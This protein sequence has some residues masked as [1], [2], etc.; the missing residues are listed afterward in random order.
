MDHRAFL[1]VMSLLPQQ[2]PFFMARIMRCFFT[3]FHEI[4]FFRTQFLCSRL[5]ICL[6]RRFYNEEQGSFKSYADGGGGA[7][8]N[9]NEDLLTCKG[10]RTIGEGHCPPSY[11]HLIFGSTAPHLLVG[12][13]LLLP[14]WPLTSP[15]PGWTSSSDPDSGTTRNLP[16]RSS[17][18]LNAIL[19][20]KWNLITLSLVE[21]FTHL[22]SMNSLVTMYSVWV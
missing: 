13:Q 17:A 14:G 22:C 6:W 20:R 7:D 19:P 21:K 2:Y 3:R 12:I 1:V 8:I 15:P 9:D 11:L 5:L 18:S 4:P 10:C 16:H